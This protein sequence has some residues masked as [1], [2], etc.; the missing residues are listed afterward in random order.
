LKKCATLHRLTFDRY[1]ILVPAQLRL[2]KVEDGRRQPL[3]IRLLRCTPSESAFV[4]LLERLSEYRGDIQHLAVCRAVLSPR[5]WKAIFA[6]VKHAR[7]FR[8]L[9]VLELDEIDCNSLSADNARKR[10]ESIFKHAR[11]LQILSLSNWPA[12][13]SFDSHMFER[14]ISLTEL[15]FA[16]AALTDLL[17]GELPPHVRFANFSRCNF[18]SVAL[19]R[20]FQMLSKVGHPFSLLLADLVV[21]GD[22]WPLFFTQ[23]EH[24]E[25]MTHLSQF[26]WS[27]NPLSADNIPQWEQFFIAGNSVKFLAV[28]RI[29]TQQT[30]NDLGAL[31]NVLPMTLWGLSVGGD[32]QHCF[33]GQVHALCDQL[34]PAKNGS[35]HGWVFGP[36]SQPRVRPASNASSSLHF[37]PLPHFT[38]DLV[39][40]RGSS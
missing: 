24:F 16:K 17:I 25:K 20:L 15:T 10:L 30:V 27:G 4:D 39:I 36:N 9:E 23:L 33:T 21:N 11:S 19:G 29:F 5:A 31:V 1:A 38:C 7:T 32:T 13:P 28:D 18:T 22:Q 37:L 8:T 12:P 3:S 14:C 35:V 34:A 26:D 40:P 6:A 2:A